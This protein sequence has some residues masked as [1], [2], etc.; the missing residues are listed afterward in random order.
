MLP[1]KHGRRYEDSRLLAR[2]NALHHGT[3][4]DLGLAEANVAAQ[5]AVHRPVGLHIVLDLGNAAE[6]I[7]GLLVGKI[8]LKLALP[9]VIRREG[10]AL[11]LGALGIQLD[12]TLG[13]P[14]SRPPLSRGSPRRRAC[15]AARA[16][17]RRRR[18]IWR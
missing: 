17:C 16:R 8:L 18:C 6:L 14:P 11:D 3:Q 7:V 15:S 10:V 5:Q 4:R 1:R 2:E 12:E 9:R 13:R